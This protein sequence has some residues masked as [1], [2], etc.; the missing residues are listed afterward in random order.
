MIFGTK[1]GWEILSLFKKFSQ[2]FKFGD[3]FKRKKYNFFG[4]QKNNLWAAAFPLAWQLFGRL[5]GI[6]RSKNSFGQK[7]EGKAKRRQTK[8]SQM[9]RRANS[10]ERKKK[11]FGGGW[12]LLPFPCFLFHRLLISTTFLRLWPPSTI[13]LRL[14]RISIPIAKK[15]WKRRNSGFMNDDNH[16]PSLLNFRRKC[17]TFNLHNE[18]EK[19]ERRGWGW[20][21]F[22]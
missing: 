16:I 10:W 20:M 7:G 8:M 12:L 2:G 14:A 11:S 17:D 13:Y 1:N 3:G 4:R 5:V 21:P 15:K 18:M 9:R 6:G 19:C 22:S